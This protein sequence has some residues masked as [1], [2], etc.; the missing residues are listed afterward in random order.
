MDGV[1]PM[2]A[3]QPHTDWLSGI[4]SRMIAAVEGVTEENQ[5]RLERWAVE[6]SEEMNRRNG[7][8]EPVST[9]GIR[10]VLNYWIGCARANQ[11]DLVLKSHE[12]A[13]LLHCLF[14]QPFRERVTCP[15]CKGE[16]RYKKNSKWTECKT[17]DHTG[18]IPAPLIRECWRT[19]TAI[20]LAREIVGDPKGKWI[21]C[22]DCGLDWGHS[23]CGT[24]KGKQ[25]IYRSIPPDYSRCPLLCDALMDAGCDD[26]FILSHLAGTVHCEACVVAGEIAS[27]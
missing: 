1:S 26:S 10:G 22:P 14:G 12:A 5:E 19:S 13:S 9:G 4:P 16:R 8:E 20:D 23:Y 17:C 7:S 15:E 18:T 24:C 11:N 6:C 21:K 25:K 3:T 27:G 2:T